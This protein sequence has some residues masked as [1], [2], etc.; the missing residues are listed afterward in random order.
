MCRDH[1]HGQR[2]CSCCDPEARRAQRREKRL[3][4]RGYEGEVD[5]KFAAA[6]V[7]ERAAMADENP[8]AAFDPSP[9]VRTAAARGPL[10][11]QT[12][13]ILSGDEKSR[14]RAAVAGNPGCSPETLYDLSGDEDQSVRLA[15]AR[16]P[17]TP[18]EALAGMAE[19]LDRRRDLCVSRALA[20][21]PRTPTSAL[22]EW[23]RGGTEG[24]RT[25]ARA[26]LRKRAEASAQAG[27]GAVLDGAEGLGDGLDEARA[28]AVDEMDEALGLKV[29]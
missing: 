13:S 10:T 8:E 16:H 22:E 3:R 19:D 12:E 21:N 18:P 29:G 6:S 4:E 11:E 1:Q 20:K 27:A 14:V 15:V 26:A 28:V 5:E 17:S 23:I 2:R 25:L 24:Q 7:A 9:T